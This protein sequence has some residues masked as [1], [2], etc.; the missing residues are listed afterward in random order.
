MSSSAVRT[1]S[2][3]PIVRAGVFETPFDR[4]L[5]GGYHALLVYRQSLADCC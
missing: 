4:A 2:R 3:S 1:D 5:A